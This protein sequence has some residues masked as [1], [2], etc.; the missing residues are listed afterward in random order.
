MRPPAPRPQFDR[1]SARVG[2]D[3][4][5]ARIPPGFRP[6]LTGFYLASTAACDAGEPIFGR[7]RPQSGQCRGRERRVCRLSRAVV[8]EVIN[9]TYIWVT[10]YA[11]FLC[12]RATSAS[13]NTPPP[14]R[15]HRFSIRPKPI[16]GPIGTQPRSDRNLVTVRQKP[17]RGTTKTRLQSS[18]NMTVVRAMSDFDRIVAKFRSDCDRNPAKMRP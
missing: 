14:T 1:Y 5:F 4:E 15:H 8:Q 13:A 6:K 7:R 3:S 9:T 2:P 10:F 18:Q 16:P 11:R 12:D 17:D